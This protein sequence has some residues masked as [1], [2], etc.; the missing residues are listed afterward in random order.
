[1][2]RSIKW[3]SGSAFNH[4]RLEGDTWHRI[5]RYK[6]SEGLWFLLS[7]PEK[8]YI[9]GIGPYSS[10]EERDKAIIEEINKRNK[11]RHEKERPKRLTDNP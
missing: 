2:P 8:T 11:E 6:T 3:G 7:S 5:E 4:G 10:K 1:M 9:C